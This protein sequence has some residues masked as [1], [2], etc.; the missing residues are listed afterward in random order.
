MV[1]TLE[2]PAYRVYTTEELQEATDN[3]AS[4]NLI[5]KSALAQHYNG[6]L[7]DGTRVLVKCL[8]L[9]PKYSPQ[10]LSHYMEIISKFRHRHLVSIIG[11]CIVNDQE[12]PTIAS[13]VYLISECVTNGSLRSHLT[14]WRKREMLKWPQRV[15]AAIGIARGIQFLHNLT[16]PDIVQ[17]DLNIENILLDKTLTSKISGFSLPMMSTSK[18]GKLFSENPFAVQEENDHGSA[19]P[20]EHGDRDDI[21][22]F[23]QILLEVITGK[24][25]AS[26]SELEPLRAQ[27]NR[28]LAEDPDMLKDMADPT[29]RG[30]FAVDSLSKVTEVALNCTAGDPSD[31][32]SV[33][34]VLWNL[35]YS[36]QVQDGW[37]SSESLSLSVKSQAW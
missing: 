5:K 6:Q 2:V 36:M 24:P 14:E 21:Y 8:R 32:P 23:G 9:K 18:N 26:R 35:Q 33:D 12:N 10:S 29:I 20:A 28:A 37:A 7:Q 15:T 27:V 11:H 30:T 4:S 25:T 17:N 13:S 22:Q 31:R 34:D 16:A 1:N 3:F 19:Q